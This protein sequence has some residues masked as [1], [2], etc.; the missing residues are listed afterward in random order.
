MIMAS[1]IRKFEPQLWL[2]LGLSPGETD[3]EEEFRHL[4]RR[5]V[6]R[7]GDRCLCKEC[8]KRVGPPYPAD[9]ISRLLKSF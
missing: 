3:P 2:E 8:E 9:R 1:P 7:V 5:F 6:L 4:I